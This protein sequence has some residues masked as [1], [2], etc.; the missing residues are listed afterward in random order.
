[1]TS[2]A[3]SEYLAELV[4]WIEE[5]LRQ[6][7]QQQTEEHAQIDQIR[8][9]LLS[10]DE[11]VNE[12]DRKV[13]EV[14]P[15]LQP[16][17]GVPEK[18]RSM[19][20]DAEHIRQAVESN[21]A[22]ADSALKTIRAEVEYGRSELGDVVRRLGQAIDQIGLV[23]ADVAQAQSQVAQV[24]QTLQ[25]VLERQ[26]EV[27]AQ[28]EQFGLRLERQVEVNRDMEDRLR[29]EWRNYEDERMQLVF[30]RLQI[31]GDM[32]KRNEELIEQ[33][34]REQTLRETVLQ[35]IGVWRD[36]HSRIDARLTSLE[37]ST[38][39]ALTE[40]D[41]VQGQVTLI[42]GRHSGLGERVAGMRREIAE[43]VDHVRDEFNKYNQMVE[44]QRRK[45]I[46]ALEQELRETK[47]H[48]FRPPEEP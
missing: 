36:Q 41:K 40:V 15:K 25:T 11:Q 27:E 23:A 48:A 45:Q 33:A 28:V 32:V 38:E 13:R 16:L 20:E 5:Q 14:D 10:T 2:G 22:E 35:E 18:I 29:E 26:R 12:N 43:V 17:K 42:E 9:Q 6:V 37:E 30:E 1:M 21:R 7:R 19:E 39:R 24:N 31:V 3:Q 4:D 46:E 47:F 8:R 34:T 44:K